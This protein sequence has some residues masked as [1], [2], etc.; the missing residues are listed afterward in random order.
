MGS[1]RRRRRPSS[2]LTKKCRKRSGFHSAWGFLKQAIE[3]CGGLQFM[4][5]ALYLFRK[6]CTPCF[7]AYS[8]ASSL[9]AHRLYM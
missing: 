4:I 2:L 9:M 3:S 1:L 7:S 6:H 5:I 8:P